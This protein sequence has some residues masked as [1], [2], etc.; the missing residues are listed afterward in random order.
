VRCEVYGVKKL[1]YI[2]GTGGIYQQGG[3]T[4]RAWWGGEDGGHAGG[5][6]R[7]LQSTCQGQRSFHFQTRCAAEQEEQIVSPRKPLSRVTGRILADR[8]DTQDAA[9]RQAKRRT[10]K[11]VGRGV[12]ETKRFDKGATEDRVQGNDPGGGKDNN[13]GAETHP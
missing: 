6:N 9:E 8:R 11:D 5:A 13:G 4:R 7:L 1:F 2:P 10:G 12:G 3:D